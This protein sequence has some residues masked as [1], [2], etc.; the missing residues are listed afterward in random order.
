[1]TD[2]AFVKAL[3]GPE[4]TPSEIN[5]LSC[6]HTA[7]HTLEDL[8]KAIVERAEDPSAFVNMIWELR[9]L[10]Q[11][12]KV[13][14]LKHDLAKQR[15]ADDDTNFKALYHGNEVGDRRL[16]EI[17]RERGLWGLSDE[18]DLRIEQEA[19]PA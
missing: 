14:L 1:M 18:C 9:S 11:D 12:L 3:R 17:V 6:L 19:H 7:I 13:A 16:A 2:Q 5:P 10:H 8:K 15:R 4:D